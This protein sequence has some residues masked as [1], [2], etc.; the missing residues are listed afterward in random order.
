VVEELRDKQ[1]MATGPGPFSMASADLVSAQLLAAGFRD[2]TFERFDAP[3]CIGR[4]L[5]EAVTFAVSIGPAGELLRQ[6]SAVSE[7]QRS[8]VLAALRSTLSEFVR[9]DGVFAPS[10]TWIVTATAEP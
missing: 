9:D 10:S 1:V 6:A 4:D 2:V 5:D 8:D 7:R 3:I